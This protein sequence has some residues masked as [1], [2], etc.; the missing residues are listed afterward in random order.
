MITV[1]Y[2]T[3]L[4]QKTHKL[5]VQ[6]ING[7]TINPKTSHTDLKDVLKINFTMLQNYKKIKQIKYAVK[8]ITKQHGNNQGRVNHI[9]KNHSY[10]PQLITNRIERT[11]SR[12]FQELFIT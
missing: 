3:S 8:Y 2:Y 1:T 6:Y 10:Q 11:S 9:D 12:T 7:P 4:N 5:L